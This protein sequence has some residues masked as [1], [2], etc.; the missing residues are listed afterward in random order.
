MLTKKTI[1]ADLCV[2]GGGIA[3]CFT[4]ISASRRGLKVV[5]MHERPVLGG[6]ASSE[7]RMWI[8]GAQG[9]DQ[10]ETGLMEEFALKSLYYNPTKNAYISDS[11]LLNMVE[12]EKNITLLLNCTCMDAKI[13][14]GEYDYN[15]DIRIK[16]VRGY[17]MTTQTFIDVKAKFYADCSGDSILAKLSGALFNI[18]RE[19][20]EV[21]GENTFVTKGDN[22]TMG[23]SLLIQARETSKEVPFVKLPW[24]KRLTEK[25]FAN[26]NPDLYKAD[27]N[28]WYLELGGDKDTIKDSEKIAKDLRGLALGTWA[29]L[30]TNK[31]YNAQNFDLDFLGYLPGKRESRR[32]V[33]EYVLTGN[34]V[35]KGVKFNDTIA[36]GG[37]PMDDHY[38]GGFFHKGMPNAYQTTTVPYSIPYRI[39]YSK[40]VDNLYFA[41]RNVSTSHL[42]L[43]TVRVMATCGVMGE[44]VGTACA[45]AVK[46]GL[47]PHGVYENKLSELQQD[48]LNGDC[49]LPHI[50]R[51]VS[52]ACKDA[53]LV[54]ASE[55]INNG[56]D[57]NNVI[58]GEVDNGVEVTNGESV[59]YQINGQSVKNIHVVFDSNLN[60]D[61]INGNWIEKTHLTRCNTLLDSPIMNMPKTLVK[62]FELKIEYADGEVEVVSV[63]ENKRRYYNFAVTDGAVKSILLTPKSN[64]GDSEKTRIISFDF[65]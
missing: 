37:W 64:Y 46:N 42:A 40:N 51:Q 38:P 54:G 49:F 24:A 15:R 14:K 19:G 32:Y 45:L 23:N 1:S 62:D 59:I 12:E 22:M 21:Y 7:I 28:F 18:G 26:R 58:Y 10:R 61:T 60:R 2:V 34:D 39:L 44:A 33:G 27:E 9:E 35:S 16:R 17:Q 55:I 50:D 29:H 57:R 8:C 20:K 30:K 36:Y 56:K 48:L 43:S 31:K 11:I 41:G 47:S 53:K 5:L 25:D 6:N 3:G 63:T 4:A 65:N 52:K 13:E